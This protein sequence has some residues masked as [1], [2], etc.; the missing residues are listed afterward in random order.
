[1]LTQDQILQLLREQTPYLADEF[2]VSKIG[3]FG[4]FVEGRS[5]DASDIDIV[6]EFER[7][8]GLRFM[9]LGEYLEELFGRK[10]DILTPTGIKAIRRKTVAKRITESIVYV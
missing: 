10:I 4:S 8:I 1:M 3:L 2:G 5:H 7:P 6:V 9:E